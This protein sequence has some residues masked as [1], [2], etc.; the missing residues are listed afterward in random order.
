MRVK[1]T[2]T[3]RILILPIVITII[4]RYEISHTP[5][6]RKGGRLGGRVI[7]LHESV[8]ITTVLSQYKRKFDERVTEVFF[9]QASGYSFSLR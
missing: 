7:I 8:L 4:L 3:I 9:W 5:I 2:V 1:G 6:N